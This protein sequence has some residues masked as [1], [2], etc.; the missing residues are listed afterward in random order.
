V[1]ADPQLTAS[2]AR[3]APTTWRS[4]YDGGQ[5]WAV[6]APPATGASRVW[7]LCDDHWLAEN[8]RG[9]DVQ[10]DARGGTYVNVTEPRAYAIAN[11]GRGHV[12]R[13]SPDAPGVTLYEFAFVPR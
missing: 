12:L 1:D 8:Q 11:T 6:L 10:L 4:G 13:V 2:P 9:A 5:V 7:V 3:G